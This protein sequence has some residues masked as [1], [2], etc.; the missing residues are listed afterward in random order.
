MHSMSL[1]F[2]NY[3]AL[4]VED[5]I[6]TSLEYEMILEKIGIKLLATC[7]NPMQVKNKLKLELPD[8]II[9]DLH[10]TGDEMGFKV[11]EEIQNLFIPFIVITGYPREPYMERSQSLNAHSFLVKP[12]NKLSLEFEFKKMVKDIFEKENSDSYFFI[13]DR[14]NRVKVPKDKIIYI[15]IDR[16]YSSIHTENKKFLLKKSLAKL[17]ENLPKD[18]FT[19]IHRG[20]IINLNHIKSVNFV[21]SQ[22]EL[23]NGE[24][25]KVGKL[26]EAN[27][28]K[29]LQTSQ[30]L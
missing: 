24:I 5:D 16:N 3:K 29:Y 4:I 9:L 10:L 23:S 2:K 8:F 6:L 1:S 19:Q 20:S 18:I 28:K 17:S 25:L 22:L 13:K 7:S 11:I 21:M 30:T 14:K 15:E 12:V 26:Y 27:L